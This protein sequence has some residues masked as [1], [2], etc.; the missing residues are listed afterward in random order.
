MPQSIVVEE[1]RR[2]QTADRRWGVPMTIGWPLLLPAPRRGPRHGLGDACSSGTL[3]QVQY[4]CAVDSVEGAAPSPTATA[5]KIRAG[6]L[7]GGLRLSEAPQTGRGQKP[8]ARQP[9]ARPG[10][11]GRS[12]G[13][14]WETRQARGSLRCAALQLRAVR[15]C[16][17]GRQKIGCEVPPAI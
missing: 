16:V 1:R 6:P 11:H 15:R 7:P 10:T 9:A 3:S 2:V 14:R 12:R 17:G 4:A 5:R 8:E 13:R